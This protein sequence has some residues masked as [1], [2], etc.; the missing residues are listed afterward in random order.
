MIKDNNLVVDVLTLLNT[1]SIALW[2][3]W[4]NI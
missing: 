3:D 4:E 2:D 1:I